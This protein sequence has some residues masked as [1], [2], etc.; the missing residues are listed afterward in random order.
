[1]CDDGP[2]VSGAAGAEIHDTGHF[3]LEEDGA[4][5]ANHIRRFLTKQVVAGQ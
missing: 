5:I 4:V 3:A 2:S 1:V